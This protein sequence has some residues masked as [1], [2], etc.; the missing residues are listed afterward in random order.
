MFNIYQFEKQAN[1]D[2]KLSNKWARDTDGK[3]SRVSRRKSD[4]SK[5]ILRMK[6][7]ILIRDFLSDG[8]KER[9]VAGYKSRVT[10]FI[11]EVGIT[12]V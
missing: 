4:H 7:V 11:K 9:L 2:P 1:P 3:A 6:F 5:F 8:V 12:L 10:S